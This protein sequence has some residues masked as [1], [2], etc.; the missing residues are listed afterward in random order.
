M[1][2]F[3]QEFLKGL[4]YDDFLDRY[5]TDEQRQRWN[6]AYERTSLTPTQSELLASFPREM[7]VLVLAGAW[8]GDCIEQC[9]I[10]VRFAEA[11]PKIALRF[12]DRDDHE[13][14]SKS[15]QICGAAR[16]PAVMFLSEDDFPCGRYGDRTLA[17]Y[18]EMAA[19]T[20]GNACATGL[21]GEAA[22][23]ETVQQEWLDEFERIQLMLR[24]SGRLRKKH[25]D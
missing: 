19:N 7:K 21:G 8:C 10:F 25:G 3:G 22:L 14:L 2:D 17:K 16:V 4:H 1:H 11:S 24:T 20:V 5:A 23:N 15:L 18:R 6:A 9:P 13:L 12:F